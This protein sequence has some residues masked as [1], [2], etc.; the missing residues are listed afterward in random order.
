MTQE[1]D[2]L[3]TVYLLCG[4]GGIIYQTVE[5]PTRSHIAQTHI[6]KNLVRMLAVVGIG[7]PITGRTTNYLTNFG[8]WLTQKTVKSRLCN[9]NVAGRSRLCNA[10]VAGRKL[11]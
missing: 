11:L 9:A 1:Q 6:L 4:E 7:L 5:S 8:F 3:N 10:N 2:I